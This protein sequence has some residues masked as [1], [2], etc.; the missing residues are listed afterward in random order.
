MVP[1]DSVSSVRSA[2]RQ[3]PIARKTVSDPRIVTSERSC[4][5]FINA[6][7]VGP[8]GTSSKR[9]SNGR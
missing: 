1:T 2:E 9:K 6:T 8:M 7:I 3:E 5:S 4:L